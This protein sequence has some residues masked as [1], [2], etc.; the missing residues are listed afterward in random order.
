VT[1]STRQQH[2]NYP[3]HAEPAIAPQ[4]SGPT[5][6]HAAHSPALAAA[7]Q[8]ECVN[9][10]MQQT[11]PAACIR[12][13]ACCHMQIPTKIEVFVGFGNGAAA[14]AAGVDGAAAAGGSMR[15]LGYLSFDSNERSNHQARELKSVHVTVDAELVRLV[16]HRCHVNKLNIYNQVRLAGCAAPQQ[17]E[18]LGVTGSLDR[19]ICEGH[20][21]PQT[22]K[23]QQCH[24]VGGLCMLDVVSKSTQQRACMHTDT[25][26][27]VTHMPRDTNQ[28]WCTH[29][30]VHDKYGVHVHAQ[31]HPRVITVAQAARCN[32]VPESLRNKCEGYSHPQLAQA[33][34]SAMQG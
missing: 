7:K 13:P 3:L 18:L 2:Q 26:P 21:H 31:G 15:R 27:G 29:R 17:H 25:L 33:T 6:T 10:A 24:A 30:V 28:Q 5:I 23:R 14:A 22:A 16:I 34:S 8:M 1:M 11:A 12:L 32:W 19:N 4:Q 9:S 20:S